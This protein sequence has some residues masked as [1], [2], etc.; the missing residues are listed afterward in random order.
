MCD[1]TREL[2]VIADV[3]ETLEACQGGGKDSRVIALT[4]AKALWH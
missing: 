4:F 2:L 3:Q 1:I